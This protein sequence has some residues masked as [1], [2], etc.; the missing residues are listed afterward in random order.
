MT[1]SGRRSR[2]RGLTNTDRHIAILCDR[3]TKLVRGAHRKRC[4]ESDLSMLF[5]VKSSGESNHLQRFA[6]E[7]TDENVNLSQKLSD[8]NAKHC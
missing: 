1:H 4:G 5:A 6:F 8:L 2:S 3:I 7:A